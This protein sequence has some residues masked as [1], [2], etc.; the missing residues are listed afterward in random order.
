M[1]DH[2][3]FRRRRPV[4][5]VS[6]R[7]GRSRVHVHRIRSW[8]GLSPRSSSFRLDIVWELVLQPGLRTVSSAPMVGLSPMPFILSRIYDISLLI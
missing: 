6:E 1:G 8:A 4:V 5:A 3:D 2:L 7:G